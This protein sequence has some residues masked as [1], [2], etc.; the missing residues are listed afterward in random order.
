MGMMPADRELKWQR[1]FRRFGLPG[2]LPEKD[3]GTENDS[4]QRE[5][6]QK[7]EGEK[8]KETKFRTAR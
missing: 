8:D 6:S 7:R 4:K 3:A 5:N 1:V 2:S